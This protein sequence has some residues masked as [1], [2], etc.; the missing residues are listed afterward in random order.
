MRDQCVP[1]LIQANDGVLADAALFQMLG[2]LLKNVLVK[3]AQHEITKLLTC[4][5]LKNI[6]PGGSLENGCIKPSIQY[7][8]SAQTGTRVFP[9]L[10]G[11]TKRVGT[12]STPC[13]LKECGQTGTVCSNKDR[14]L[15]ETHIEG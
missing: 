15:A 13:R 1:R 7:N 6:H 11:Q 3:I 14:H 4:V 5:T 2:D 12:G 9:V 10:W 8:E